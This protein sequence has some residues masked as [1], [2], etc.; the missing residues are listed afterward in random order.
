MTESGS[1]E[2]I[3]LSIIMAAGMVRGLCCTSW[4][5]GILFFK[6]HFMFKLL[7]IIFRA[8]IF[9]L[10]GMIKHFYPYLRQQNN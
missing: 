9:C 7:K 5:F 1:N 3:N 4:V 2:S 6:G 8:Y 10:I